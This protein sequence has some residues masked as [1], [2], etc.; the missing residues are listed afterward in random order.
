AVGASLFYVAFDARRV[1]GVQRF[2]LER[3]IEPLQTAS[4]Q[5]KGGRLTRTAAYTRFRVAEEPFQL[6]PRWCSRG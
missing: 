6:A 2:P 3:F 5:E 4:M 1:D